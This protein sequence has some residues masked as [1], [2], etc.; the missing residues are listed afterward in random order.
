MDEDPDL[1]R[2]V[3]LSGRRSSGELIPATQPHLSTSLT[4]EQSLLSLLIGRRKVTCIATHAADTSHP[5]IP[6]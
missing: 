5:I 1:L 3:V 4:G 2:R 6:R